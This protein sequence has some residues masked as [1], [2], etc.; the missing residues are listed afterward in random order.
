MK[1]SSPAYFKDHSKETNDL[2]F[3]GFPSND[4]T[5]FAIEVSIPE[6]ANRLAFTKSIK[7]SLDTGAITHS[8]DTKYKISDIA[9]YGANITGNELKL[10]NS[11]LPPQVPGLN[12]NLEFSLSNFESCSLQK[13]NLKDDLKFS[14]PYLAAILSLSTPLKDPS[15]AFNASIVLGNPQFISGGAEIDVTP[16][17]ISSVN[18]LAT[19][20]HDFGKTTGFLN[21][22]LERHEKLVGFTHHQN[23][24][25]SPYKPQLAFKATYNLDNAA[26]TITIGTGA[27]VKNPVVTFAKLKIDSN[28]AIGLALTLFKAPFTVQPSF[29]FK[30]KDKSYKYGVK[31][32]LTD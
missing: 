16:K 25:N 5:W 30:V 28:F 17:A 22:N 31:V 3:K 1:Q 19:V 13:M 12:N 6:K 24:I 23:F 10:S 9:T 29:E 14:N 26:S 27:N 15:L 2:L 32:S 21:N 4:K 8:L 11:Y 20:K 18:F 7:S